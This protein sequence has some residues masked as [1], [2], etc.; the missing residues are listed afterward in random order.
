VLI[1]ERLDQRLEKARQILSGVVDSGGA[2]GMLLF[3]LCLR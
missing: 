1:D 3:I 2:A